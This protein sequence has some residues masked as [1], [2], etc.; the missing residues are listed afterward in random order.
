VSAAGAVG[1]PKTVAV[2]LGVAAP[3]TGLVGAWGFDE[4]LC[5]K[6]ADASGNSNTGTISGATRTTQGKFGGALDYDGVNDWVTV[7]DKPSL[8]LTTGMTL[9]GWVYPTR[10]GDAGNWKAL[11]VKETNSGLA[12]ALYPFGDRGLPSGHAATANELWASAPSA[13]TLNTWSHVAVTYDGTTIRFYVN[14]VQVGTRVQSGPLQ[15]SSQ[16][17]RF[18]GDAVW[19]E[20]F[21]G[22]LDEIRIY[23]RPLTAAQVQT[24]MT[25]P[26]T[27]AALLRAVAKGKAKAKRVA[28]TKS[29]SAARGKGVNP[30]VKIK[31]YRAKHRHGWRRVAH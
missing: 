31:R 5:T 25:T 17:L 13:L 12:W 26:V 1:S 22:R 7:A 4:S 19:S 21:A 14:G 10:A 15:T 6:T 20:W 8:D 30:G 3:V 28:K 9:E 27:Q 23:N 24:D 2:T 18:G 11:A 16:P 29:R